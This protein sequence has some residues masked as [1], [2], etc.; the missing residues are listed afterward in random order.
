MTDHR[1]TAE[2]SPAR[3][4][5]V[6]RKGAAATA[7][8]ALVAAG[9]LTA[10]AQADPSRVPGGAGH[11]VQVLHFAVEFSPFTII[12]VPPTARQPGDYRAGDYLV[13]S[14]QLSDRAGTKVGTEGGSGLLTKVGASGFQ[15]HYSLAVRLREGQFVV[16]G[17]ASE[18]PTK[19]LAVVGGTGRYL[20]AIG[21]LEL[22]EHPDGTGSLT[23]R[24]QRS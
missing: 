16:A 18:A 11:H 6:R 2:P 21:D 17:L 8:A 12:D 19:R 15:V 24:W 13:F 7:A 1:T 5:R 22:V 23:I 9:A 3:R 20:G 10:S 14:D 4:F